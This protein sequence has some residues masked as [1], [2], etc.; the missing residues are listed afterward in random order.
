MKPPS[1]MRLAIPTAMTIADV[2]P[3]VGASM[4]AHNRRPRPMIENN[5]PIGSGR[6]AEG[7]FESGT[8]TTAPMNPATAIGTFTRKME[9]H[10]NL[11]SSRP[12]AIGPTATPRPIVPAHAPMARAR[13]PGSRK[14]SLMI[15]S[16]AGM[17]RAAP[18]PIRARHAISGWTDEENAAPTDPPANTASPNRKKRLRPNRSARLPPTNKSPAKTIA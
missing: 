9:P 14:T 10:Q 11:D 8:S 17:A 6:S 18:A 2:H 1:A 5:D 13:S 4:M 12:P 7:F 3:W 16:D 15:D